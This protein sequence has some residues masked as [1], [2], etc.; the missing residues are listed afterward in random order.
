VVVVVEKPAGMA[1]QPTSREPRGTV[2]QHLIALYPALA[3]VGGVDHAGLVARLET[4]ASGLVLAA[5]E[6]TTYRALRR[7]VDHQRVE[8]VYSVLVEGHLK[9]QDVI[10]QPIGNMKHT[11]KQLAVSRE[12]RPARTLYR[13]LRYYKDGMHDYSLLE[14][15]PESG[16]LHQVRVH[17][18]WYGYP[19]VGDKLYGSRQQPLLSERVFLHLSCVNFLHPVTGN[20]VRV[21]SALPPELYAILRYLT[22]PKNG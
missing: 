18:A 12:G 21:E 9:G 6:E 17:L 4:E 19:L 8:T 5:K 7:L 20:P 2:A 10:E 15:R 1:L 3:H 11:R 13:G 14:A 22:R 16:R